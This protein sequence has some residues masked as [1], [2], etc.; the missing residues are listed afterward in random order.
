M[1]NFRIER[2][3]LGQQFK[4]IAGVDEAGRGAL[5]GPVVAAAVVLP[6]QWIGGPVRGWLRE[7]NDSK[8]LSPKKRKELAGHLLAEAL[9]VGVGSA[10]NREIDLINI[11]WASLEAMKR[12]VERLN[13]EPDYLL[14]DGFPNRKAGFP[15]SELGI[16]GGDR[17][18]LSVAAASIVAKV[19]RDE[20]M[21]LFDSHFA[22]YHLAKNKGYGTK[23]H[24]QALKEKGPTPLHR[25]TFN[26]E[27]KADL[28]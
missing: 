18:S 5:F 26:L 7:V 11:Y 20:M 23:E 4:T 25:L 22:G 13:V 12:A 17:K 27:G 24:Y 1:A 14:I 8:M 16:P 10:S 2:R 6:P 3:I 15:C 21:V 9:A 28:R 19:A